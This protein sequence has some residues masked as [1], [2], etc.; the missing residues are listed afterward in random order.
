MTHAPAEKL[1]AEYQ[2]LTTG[3]GSV[4]FDHWSTISLTGT[5]RISFVHNM[6]TNDVR[7]LATG[8]GCE[9]FFTDVKGRIVAHVFALALEEELLLITVPQQAATMINHLD[10][11][12]IREDVQLRDDSD[13]SCWL[14]VSG[15]QAPARLNAWTDCNTA[16]LEA[17]WQ[18]TPCTIGAT[19]ILLV[20]FQAI[21]SEG[22][23]LR[24]AKSD[25]RH[26][27]H[28][29]EVAC[30]TSAWNVLRIESAL[31][32]FGIDFDSTNL[33]QEVDRNDQAISF[34]KGCYLGQETIA[35]IDALGHVNQRLTSLR[36]SDGEVPPRGTKLFSA[37]KEAGE[38]TSS[39]WSPR[40]DAPL[41]L[42][43][44]RRGSHD[45]GSLLQSKFGQATVLTL[46]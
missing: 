20:R 45:P 31:P 6:C 9:T 40:L 13:T 34:N 42:A 14:L 1:L 43:M 25:R 22:F 38:V 10:R 12:I 18:H 17:P 11:Y 16:L 7:R 36:F 4:E 3:C 15:A 19:E 5:D 2:S 8:D 26:L 41:A 24:Y 39:C 44:A 23:L 21:W 33:P 28:L 27:Q 30:S 46:P 35:R 32:L 29:A 37:G